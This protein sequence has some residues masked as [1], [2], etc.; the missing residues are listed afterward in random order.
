[1]NLIIASPTGPRARPVLASMMCAGE[2]EYH[3]LLCP[4]LLPGI[5]QGQNSWAR[6]RPGARG[7]SDQGWNISQPR[8][9]RTDTNIQLKPA[10]DWSSRLYS[11]LWLARSDPRMVES[12]PWVF[13]SPYWAQFKSHIYVRV[14]QTSDSWARFHHDRN[15]LFPM[16]NFFQRTGH[17]FSVSSVNEGSEVGK[18]LKVITLLPSRGDSL[19]A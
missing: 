11:S 3:F 12:S 2:C 7:Q 10:S 8:V 16:T 4:L 5:I 19:W 9:T 1:M 14:S 18:I 17:V 13:E 15:Q 6:A